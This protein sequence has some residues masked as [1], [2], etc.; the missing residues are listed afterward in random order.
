MTYQTKTITLNDGKATVTV[1]ESIGMDAFDR[2]AIYPV[3][4]YNR[5]KRTQ[6][7][8]ASQFTEALIRSTVDG[9]LGFVWADADDGTE[10][11]LQ[12]AFEGWQTLKPLDVVRWANAL[13]EVNQRVVNP[14]A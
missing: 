14:P 3:L 12:A 9:D 4:T 2:Q 7:Q 8:R 10:A 13:N 6:V 1:R 5:A 11:E